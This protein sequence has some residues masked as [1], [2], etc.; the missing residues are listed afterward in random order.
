MKSVDGSGLQRDAEQ[1]KRDVAETK[2]T[3][4]TQAPQFQQEKKVAPKSNTA[5][6]VNN[7]VVK[8]KRVNKPTN[9]QLVNESGMPESYLDADSTGVMMFRDREDYDICQITDER[10]GKVLAFIGGYA[11]QFN[12]NMVEINSMERVEQCL[13]GLTKLFRHKLMTQNLRSS[14]NKGSEGT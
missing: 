13:Q 3:S 8:M 7:P 5:N 9:I 2:S 1:T 4:N 14:V 11:L 10:T 12:F 6:V